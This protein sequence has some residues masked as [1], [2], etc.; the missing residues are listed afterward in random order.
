MPYTPVGTVE[1][2]SRETI[3]SDGKEEEHDDDDDG[4]DDD[5]KWTT[6]ANQSLPLLLP[7]PSASL[8]LQVSHPNGL[9]GHLSTTDK[10]LWLYQRLH[11]VLGSAGAGVQAG[12]QGVQC[13]CV[14]VRE[15]DCYCSI[16]SLVYQPADGDNH[17]IL[18]CLLV[19]ALLLQGLQ[20]S[21]PCIKPLHALRETVREA[22][23]GTGRKEGRGKKKVLHTNTTP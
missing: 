23:G 1:R 2:W 17:L 13:M 4:D 11:N 12:K 22:E 16:H 5:E 20:N 15:C 19:Q 8:S 14:C 9:L 10:P 3:N 7:S 18:L 21:F 6:R